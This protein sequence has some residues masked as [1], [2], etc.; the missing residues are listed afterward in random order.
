MIRLI[1]K[2][3][4]KLEPGTRVEM[5]FNDGDREQKVQGC[6]TDTDHEES[7]ELTMD[8]GDILYLSYRDVLFLKLL[9]AEPQPVTPAKP[10]PAAPAEPQPVVVPTEEVPP[11]PVTEFRPFYQ[12]DIEWPQTRDDELKSAFDALPKDNKAQLG[13][14][15]N[16]MLF[17]LR[18]NDGGKVHRAAANL[19]ALLQENEKLAHDRQTALFCAALLRR[20]SENPAGILAAGGAYREAAICNSMA[21]RYAEAGACAVLGICAGAQGEELNELFTML[22]EA[23]VAEGDLQVVAWLSGQAS[24]LPDGYMQE[25]LLHLASAA[26]QTLPRDS[27]VSYALRQLEEHYPGRTILDLVEKMTQ[28]GEPAEEP[29]PSVQ[30]I[31]PEEESLIPAEQES[32]LCGSIVRLSWAG[33]RGTIE[34]AQQ[35]IQFAY[36]D[37]VNKGLKE[38]IQAAQS[39]DMGG[40]VMDVCFRLRGEWAV[41][42]QPGALERARAAMTDISDPR[43]FD[44]A[45]YWLERALDTRSAA[46]AL[47]ECLNTAL[48]Q[49]NETGNVEA[50]QHAAELCRLHEEAMPQTWQ[51]YFSMGQVCRYLG[52]IEQAMKSCEEAERRCTEVKSFP[53]VLQQEISILKK[54]YDATGETI[55]LE[56]LA[57][58]SRQMRQFVADHGE[59]RSKMALQRFVN[60]VCVVNLLRYAC[61]QEDLDSVHTL[62][63]QLREEYVK[64]EILDDIKT[65]IHDLE[66]KYASR[67]EFPVEEEI[68]PVT[69][70]EA[71]PAEEPVMEIEESQPQ[72]EEEEPEPEPA[73]YVDTDGWDKLNLTRQQVIDYALAISGSERLPRMLAYLKAGAELN[74]DGLL[75]VYRVVSLATDNPAFDCDYSV[76]Y[77]LGLLA[78]GDSAYPE[79]NNYCMAAACLRAV[80]SNGSVFGY[81]IGSLHDSIDAFNEIPSLN[82]IYDL[83]SQFNRWNNC[84][85]DSLADYHK[86][87][88]AGQRKK[89]E[90]TVH[91]AQNL[92]QQFILTPP[93]EDASFARNVET[94]KFVFARDGM[95]AVLLKKI[96]DGDTEGLAACREEFRAAWLTAGKP[97]CAASISAESIDAYINDC[98]NRA[99]EAMDIKHRAARLQGNRRNNLRSS[100]Q[101]ILA[102]ICDWYDLN[103]QGVTAQPEEGP[104]RA[105]YRRI[106]EKLMELLN[107]LAADCVA[108]REQADREKECGLFLLE[109]TAQDLLARLDGSWNTD[110]RRYLYADFLRSDWLLLDENYLPDTGAT[111]CALADYNVLARIRRH[112]EE[113]HPSYGERLGRIFSSEPQYNNYGTAE[114]IRSYLEMTGQELPE[115]LPDD[116]VPYMEQTARRAQRELSRFREEY[117][118]SLS[119][120]QIIQ[121]DPF[122]MSMEDTVRRWYLNCSETGNYGFWFTLVDHCYAQIRQVAAQYGGQLQDQLKALVANN[123]G[124]FAASPEVESEIKNLI[125]QQN[126]TVA[127][128]WMNRVR[129]GDF[130]VKFESTEA[131]SYLQ[132]FWKEFDVNFSLV[133]DA[134]LPLRAILQRNGAHKDRRGGQALVENWLSN[135]NSANPE[136]IHRLLTCLGWTNIEVKPVRV[137]TG[138]TELYRVTERDH[139]DSVRSIQHPIADFGS[140]IATTGFCVACLYGTYDCDRLLARFKALD[141]IRGAKLVLLDYPLSAPE[142]RKLARKIKKKETGLSN[143]YLVLDRV[144][145]VFLAKHYNDAAV[146]RILMATGMPFAYYQPYVADSSNPMPPE[147]FIGR[148]DE[149]LK[150]ENPN[151][152]NLIYGGRQL[153]KSALFK[154][155]RIDIDGTQG[156]RAVLVDLSGCDCARAA[157][158]LSDELTALEI[159]PAGSETENWSELAR[160]IKARLRSDE[161]LITYLLV[162]LDE[163]DTFVGDC[164]NCNYQPLA[165]LKDIQ[166]TLPERFKFVLA[167]LHNIV[168]FNREVALGRNAVITHLPSLNVKPFETPE[169]HELLVQPLSYLGFSVEDRVLISQILATTNY[170]PGL[171][172]M[173]CQK[174]IESMR[175]SNYA[176]YNEASTPPYLI[177]EDHIRRVLADNNFLAEIHNKFEI[178]LR[179]DQDQGS[180]YYTIA[181]LIGWMYTAAPSTTGYTADDL[182]N[183]ARDLDLHALTELNRE[184]MDTLLQE[185]YD[186]NILRS[187]GKDTYLFASKNFHDLLGNEEEIFNKL[188]RIGGGEE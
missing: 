55:W 100:L 4:A 119:R 173:Y 62:V 58:K 175:Q 97:L 42:V 169:A 93:R 168:R 143:T 5:K 87:D 25:L 130:D 176:G 10:Q 112:C 45:W 47:Q 164:K 107:L 66:E 105:E 131:I 41:E 188:A 35:T 18:N 71:A 52:D 13:G 6:I 179:L 120:G 122:L 16:S 145:L 178:T 19:I 142:R 181:L 144:L 157:R 74:P 158:K 70:E 136:H 111:F 124:F 1:E 23:C 162:M 38:R 60:G 24:S 151:G 155:A 12:V 161:N 127:E 84:A 54:Q 126:Y 103:S 132:Q 99:G 67:E 36:A 50:L 91:R 43:R 29:A 69:Q 59:L 3:L 180:Y 88:M 81:S 117:I 110:R 160:S 78:G 83:L 72:D 76:G 65:R 134:G 20:G 44:R 49:H 86:L 21:K 34:Y 139:D 170:F 149:L 174:L 2:K 28:Q 133:R 40:R 85:V 137:S 140:R 26:G 27:A 163:A 183:Q 141:G 56:R 7:L 51:A 129:R 109:T 46:E 9:G 75:P 148:K 135:G 102:V 77:L 114:R 152:V 116:P 63:P 37:V 172:Q 96:I 15:Y 33:E 185:L 79:L 32:L 153:G 147:M 14:L 98:W 61:A 8:S 150:I 128:D 39:R 95:P 125:E 104:A 123:Q 159:L 17:G 73:P 31:S 113:E 154:K 57:H 187:T 30:Q 48:N 171:I 90:Q 166:Q 177:T 92:Y 106:R 167:G 101:N 80:F 82:D 11:R 94:K 121:S 68:L 64:S 156:R 108:R 53:A 165:E 115:N 89:L 182:L 118:L 138:T 186:L 22:D 184:Q 146:N